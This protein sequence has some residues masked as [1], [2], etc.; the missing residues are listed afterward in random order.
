MSSKSKTKCVTVTWKIE[1]FS[2][3]LS[4]S[5]IKLCLQSPVWK[6]KT[7]EGSASWWRL[8]VSCSDSNR[9]IE[10]SLTLLKG[11][12]SDNLYEMSLITSGG[13]FPITSKSYLS[14][15]SHGSIE[16]S[17]ILDKNKKS[18]LPKDTLALCCRIRQQTI[19]PGN[20]LLRTVLQQ[21]NFIWNIEGF[22]F[23]HN[24]EKREVHQ[25]EKLLI[26]VKLFKIK[27]NGGYHKVHVELL[28]NTG[29]CSAFQSCQIDIKEDKGRVWSSIIN[30]LVFS[31]GIQIHSVT[32]KTVF[33]YKY[34]A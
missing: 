18:F 22:S 5:N 25:H 33:V 19:K 29:I 20:C 3:Y 1:N 21:V 30:S 6:T 31:W 14:Y 24:I 16:K 8:L 10:F 23:D 9:I 15:P 27:K 2:A 28:P 17:R 11:E 26:S 34:N 12:N 32:R 4:P 7:T 13:E